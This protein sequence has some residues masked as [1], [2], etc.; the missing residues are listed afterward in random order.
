MAWFS[1]MPT[2]EA[3]APL[4]P[5]CENLL[6]KP[7]NPPLCVKRPPRTPTSELASP[8]ASVFPPAAPS[9]ELRS[10]IVLLSFELLLDVRVLEKR[11]RERCAVEAIFLW[12]KPP[13]V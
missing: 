1:P 4:Q 3:N 11:R 9:I 12:G 6:A 8:E 7:C 13:L 10:P 5:L 2:Q